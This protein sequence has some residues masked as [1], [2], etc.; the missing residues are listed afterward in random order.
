MDP[1]TRLVVAEAT[2]RAM[3]PRDNAARHMGI[4]IEETRPGYARAT[5]EVRDFMVNG[6]GILH[7]GICFTLADTAF[8]YC[9][10]SHDVVTVASACS[11][12][13][14]APGKLGDRLTAEAS[15]IIKKGRA[16]ITDVTVT[17]QH[18]EVL[19][20]FRGNSRTL[21]GRVTEGL[22]PPL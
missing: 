8:A 4:T 5:L 20:V 17:N 6:H 2:T 11:I 14:L 1:E 10:N 15:E 21:S 3:Y 18:G 9:C 12:T 7:G 22:D 16:G 13:F 19:A